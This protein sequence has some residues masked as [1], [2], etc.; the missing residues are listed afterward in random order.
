MERRR[1]S[2]G[3][4]VKGRLREVKRRREL[5]GRR[6]RREEGRREV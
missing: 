1:G 3:E 5:D 6:G 2:K 4:G